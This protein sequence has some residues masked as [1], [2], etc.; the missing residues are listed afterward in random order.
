MKIHNLADLHVKCLTDKE[1]RR[2]VKALQSDAERYTEAFQKITFTSDTG[3]QAD[4]AVFFQ[5]ANAFEDHVP[6]MTLGR[7]SRTN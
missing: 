2:V 6:T 7:Q 5:M 4:G 3:R 1:R